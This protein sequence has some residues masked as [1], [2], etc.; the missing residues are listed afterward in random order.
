MPVSARSVDLLSGANL[1]VFVRNNP[2]GRPVLFRSRSLVGTHCTKQQSHQLFYVRIRDHEH[3]CRCLQENLERT[4]A[5]EAIPIAERMELLQEAASFD[6]QL[7]FTLINSDRL[8]NL[9]Q[10]VGRQIA[11]LL[12]NS[13]I[14][15]R[16]LYGVVRHDYLT[17]AH[18]TNVASYSV[19]LAERIGI[20]DRRDL[21]A[22]ATGGLLHDLGKRLIPRKILAKKGSLTPEERGIIQEH[23]QRGY[24]E[25]CAREDLSFGQLMMVYQHH[26]RVDGKGYPVRIT[27]EEIHPWARLCAVV[28]V[29]DALTAKRPYR[30]A[31]GLDNALAFLESH[32]GTQFDQEFVRC[33]TALMR[34]N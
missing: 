3:V 21:E 27:G 10:Q 26:E 9:S 16:E 13:K 32:A 24:E 34:T 29:F 22:I 14:L 25:L 4:L 28:D 2:R 12:H 5:N 31:T 33:W 20:N 7:V 11:G 18:V 15:A 19:L 8:T 17:F 1:D 6:V 23:P 30:K